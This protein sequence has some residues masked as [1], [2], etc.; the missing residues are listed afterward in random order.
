MTTR[1]CWPKSRTKTSGEE[2]HEVRDK[3]N[4]STNP[5]LKYLDQKR[6]PIPRPVPR[7]ELPAPVGINLVLRH[8]L[9]SFGAG[10]ALRVRQGS[11]ERSFYESNQSSLSFLVKMARYVLPPEPS[12]FSSV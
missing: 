8:V 9:P 7:L 6:N 3:I 12:S 2:A 5:A 1:R 11:P 4:W 10:E